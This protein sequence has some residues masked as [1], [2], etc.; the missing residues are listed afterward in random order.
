[1]L[2]CFQNNKTKEVERQMMNQGISRRSTQ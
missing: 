1:L 2:C